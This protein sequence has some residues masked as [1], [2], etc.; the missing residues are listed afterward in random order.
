MKGEVRNPVTTWLIAA[1]CCLYGW[2]WYY[3]IGNELKNYLGKEDLNPVVD[4]VIALICPFYGLYLPIKYGK[5]IFEA[6]QRAGIAGAEDKG[7]VYLLCMFLYSFGIKLMQEDLNKVW[8]GGG[9][10]SY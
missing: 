8:E 6:Q 9:A 5:L 7:L 1:I 2:Y 4:L 3:T 10:G